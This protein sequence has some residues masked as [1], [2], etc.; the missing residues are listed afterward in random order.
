MS[1]DPKPEHAAPSPSLWA[2]FKAS[3]FYDPATRAVHSAWQ[4]SAARIVPLLLAAA[5]AQAFFT[6]TVGHGL[7]AA[8][9][10]GGGAAVSSVILSA[11]TWKVP[12]LGRKADTL[13]RLARTAVSSIGGLFAA[14]LAVDDQALFHF[15]WGPAVYGAVSTA[16]LSLTKTQ[17]VNAA[18][19]IGGAFT[20]NYSA[21]TPPAPLTL[22]GTLD[23][24]TAPAEL[25]ANPNP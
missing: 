3:Q 16:L 20:P 15:A 8:V 24:P 13:V 12:S 17:L 2:R 18:A 4:E 11:A 22:G 1:N 7:L 5:A 10:A 6:A 23:I 19:N 14:S 25:S 21:V 9:I